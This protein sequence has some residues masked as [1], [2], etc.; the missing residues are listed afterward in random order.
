MRLALLTLCALA[1]ASFVLLGSVLMMPARGQTP[2]DLERA[3]FAVA[4]GR[5]ATLVLS[6]AGAALAVAI[7]RRRS[8]LTTRLASLP[9][10]ALL[11]GALW[12]TWRTPA[13]NVFAPVE[14]AGFV[15]VDDVDFLEPEDMVLGVRVGDAAKAYPVG[16]LVYHHLV[17][18]VVGGAAVV[19][20]F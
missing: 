13:E 20:T 8:S 12:L 4:W 19:A 1:A 9:L 18:D 7:W 16:Q 17:N 5:P 2:A 15:G 6:L 11:A 10:L 14:S 3:Y